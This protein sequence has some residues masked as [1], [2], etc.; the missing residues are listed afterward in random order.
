MSPAE[1]GYWV[2]H[3]SRWPPA[4]KILS[5]LALWVGGAVGVEVDTTIFGQW[6]ETDDERG[7]RKIKSAVALGLARLASIS[8]SS[9]DESDGPG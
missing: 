7:R 2:R 9:A 5:I 6:I 1:I 3:L 4:E 8:S